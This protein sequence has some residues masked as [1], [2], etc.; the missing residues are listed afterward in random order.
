M[1]RKA[2]AASGILGIATL[3]GACSNPTTEYVDR[4]YEVRPKFEQIFKIM[5]SDTT[6]KDNLKLV[7]DEFSDEYAIDLKKNY[8][9]IIVDI[10]P[11][12]AS[13][14]DTLSLSGNVIIIWGT[15]ADFVSTFIN[16]IEDSFKKDNFNKL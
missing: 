16:F 4:Y 2:I 15:P 9:T 1:R 13:H 14:T 6:V 3:F 5:T 11:N 10:T 12:D 8:Q 7:Y